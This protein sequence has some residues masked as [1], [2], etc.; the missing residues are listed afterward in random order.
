MSPL[1]F[2]L[3]FFHSMMLD[4]FHQDFE[5]RLKLLAIWSDFPSP[6]GA[7]QSWVVSST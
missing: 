5:L 3:F 7:Y 2:P 1:H 4:I 6:G